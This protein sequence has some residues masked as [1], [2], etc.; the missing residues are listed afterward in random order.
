MHVGITLTLTLNLVCEA[1]I[2]QDTGVGFIFF[3]FFFSFDFFSVGGEAL[4]CFMQVI[5][6]K[7]RVVS[8]LHTIGAPPILAVN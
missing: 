2:V 5:R 7:Q 6:A 8:A 4:T 1:E 3:F